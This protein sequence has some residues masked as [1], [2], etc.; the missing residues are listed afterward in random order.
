MQGRTKLQAPMFLGS[1]W[2]Q[3]TWSATQEKKTCLVQLLSFPLRP[4]MYP[5]GNSSQPNPPS[6]GTGIAGSISCRR[7]K[8]NSRLAGSD[9]PVE[10]A[11]KQNTVN[12]HKGMLKIS[13]FGTT[14]TSANYAYHRPILDVLHTSALWYFLIC[15]ATLSKGKGDTCS[16][17]TTAMSVRP[18]CFHS[19]RN[20]CTSA[21]KSYLTRQSS[22]MGVRIT[23]ISSV[24]T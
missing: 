6:L 14:T 10:L 21:E 12:I 11:P 13:P 1:S 18:A 2:A 22:P 3:H 19:A 17:R 8:T 5:C 4:Y 7:S 24:T 15:T 20:R 23:D 9:A 16:T